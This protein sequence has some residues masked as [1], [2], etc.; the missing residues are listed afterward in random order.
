MMMWFGLPKKIIYKNPNEYDAIRFNADEL[1]T[2]QFKTPQKVEMVGN[3]FVYGLFYVKADYTGKITDNAIFEAMMYDAFYY[4]QVLKEMKYVGF[5]I[6]KFN[7][8]EKDFNN[9]YEL[10]MKEMKLG[11]WGIAQ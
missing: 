7:G 3:D 8:Y 2:T 10:A 1:V 11:R 6:K 9:K 4:A 5:F